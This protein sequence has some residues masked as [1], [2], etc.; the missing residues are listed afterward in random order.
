MKLENLLSESKNYCLIAEESGWQ[1]I[2]A[3]S[4]GSEF[5]CIPIDGKRVACRRILLRHGPWHAIRCCDRH[6]FPL[7]VLPIAG[8]QSNNASKMI[9][10]ECPRHV[11]I[12]HMSSFA[13]HDIDWWY[14]QSI[15][16][17]FELQVGWILYGLYIHV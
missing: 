5:K 8:N 17:S 9:E 4:R 3:L 15:L 11:E 7:S 13:S 1:N 12:G 6:S 10:G 16:V 14:N 2:A